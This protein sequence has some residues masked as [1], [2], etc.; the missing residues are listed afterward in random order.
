MSRYVGNH[1][2]F[3]YENGHLW[4]DAI[5]FTAEIDPAAVMSKLSVHHLSSTDDEDPLPTG[6]AQRT[7]AIEDQIASLV[8]GQKEL[9][10]L[11]KKSAKPTVVDPEPRMAMPKARADS[12][13]RGLERFQRL[14]TP[15]ED[16]S[17]DGITSDEG[18]MSKA[19]FPMT[20]NP[21]SNVGAADVQSLIAMEMLRQ[22]KALRQKKG[23]D[24]D[25]DGDEDGLKISKF[26]K[27]HKMH[28]SHRKKTWKNV[29]QFRAMVKNRLGFVE[30]QVWRYRMWGLT[31]KPTFGKMT[32]FFKVFE[33]LFDVLETLDNET[34]MSEPQ[35]QAASQVVQLLKTMLQV[36]IDRGSWENGQYLLH[37][38]EAPG[39]QPLFGGTE[40]ALERIYAYRKGLL[41]LKSR[42]GKGK[43]DDKKDQDEI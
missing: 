37:S 38:Q 11:V 19:H 31:L 5:R 21:M 20:P 10:K 2:S 29:R 12:N 28:E 15:E 22:L 6:L 13:Q 24:S 39:Q 35:Q 23:S 25:S 27:L 16:S 36:A 8:T 30:G 4:K 41:D 17:D 43:G 14:W 40:G 34:A 32:G 18:L 3:V 42:K 9:M 33:S 26:G 1:S 7:K